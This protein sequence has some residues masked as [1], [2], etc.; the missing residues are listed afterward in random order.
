MDGIR[1]A[2]GPLGNDVLQFIND[3]G[4]LAIVYAFEDVPML[5]LLGLQRDRDLD[6]AGNIL[7]AQIGDGLDA[8][9]LEI[10]SKREQKRAA[11]TVA[12]FLLLAPAARITGLKLGLLRRIFVAHVA[13][14]NS[15]IAGTSLFL[16]FTYVQNH[17]NRVCK[18]NGGHKC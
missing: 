3:A 2:L 7:L 5:D 10:V 9:C 17:H 11:D 6:V 15:G 4:K 14:L 16:K 13:P 12:R 8:V 1:R 18:V